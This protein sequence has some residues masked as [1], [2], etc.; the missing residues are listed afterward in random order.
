MH[1]Q[2]R[3]KN[4]LSFHLNASL[5]SISLAKWVYQEVGKLYYMAN[6]KTL[7]INKL[8]LERF[9]SILEITP[10][11]QINNS[12]LRQLETVGLIAA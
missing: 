3:S 7:P 1:C 4:K 10:E 6:V 12:K 9:F 5:S 8:M 2:T 11:M